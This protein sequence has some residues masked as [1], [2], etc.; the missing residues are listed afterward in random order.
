[1][2]WTAG[3]GVWLGFRLL[4]VSRL[5]RPLAYASVGDVLLGRPFGLIAVRMDPQDAQSMPAA[6]R[7]LSS[8]T[9]NA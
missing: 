9:E 7:L 3:I 1:M 4:A 5:L 2:L 8:R 6:R